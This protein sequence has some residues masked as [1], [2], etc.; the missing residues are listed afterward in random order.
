MFKS[1]L[2]NICQ[3][4]S[5]VGQL[6]FPTYI[7]SFPLSRA[8]LKKTRR[9]ASLTKADKICQYKCQYA[10]DFQVNG[11]DM[12]ECGGSILQVCTDFNKTTHWFSHWGCRP[13]GAVS[14]ESLVTMSR[15]TPRN[16]EM[17]E[18]VSYEIDQFQESQQETCFQK[19]HNIILVW[20]C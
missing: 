7:D 13:H 9:W 20:P 3:I 6:R 19:T 12:I 18:T 17:Y 14:H 16:Q 5:C 10:V 15:A 11:I 1:D 4:A 2:V 8:L